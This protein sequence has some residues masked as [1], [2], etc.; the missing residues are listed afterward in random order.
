MANHSDPSEEQFSHPGARP[1]S[2]L[3]EE[4]KFRLLAENVTDVFWIRSADMQEL[5]YL[6]PAFERIW[7]RKRDELLA[8]PRAWSSF[9][10]D[11][12]RAVVVRGFE[13]LLRSGNPIA[14]EYR[15]HR[16]DGT[17]RWIQTRGFLVRDE[18]GRPLATTGIVTDITERRENELA[19]LRS[20]E[21]YREVESQLRQ[22]QKIEALG[23]LAAGVA[24]EFN[25][26]LQGLMAKATILRLRTDA[27]DLQ[28]LGSEME[29]EIRRGAT[30]TR[31]MLLFAQQDVMQKSRFSLR[32]QVEQTGELLSHVLPETIAITLETGE[33]VRVE[34]DPGQI[35]Q[36][37]VNLAINARD[38]MPHGGRLILRAGVLA[39]EAFAE[40]ED[41]G[42]GIAESMRSRIFEPFFTTRG[43]GKGTGLGLS[44]AYGIVEQHGGRI[45]VTSVP[46]DGSRFR[47][48]LPAIE[49]DPTGPAEA[50]APESVASDGKAP[51]LLVEDEPAVREGLV[52]VLEMAGYPVVAFENAEEALGAEIEQP[53]SI[54]ISDLT[55]PGMNGFTLAQQMTQR[56]ES[57]QVVLMSGYMTR[58]ERPEGW[59]FLQKPFEL[60]ELLDCLATL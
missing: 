18:S 40:V 48:I 26:L 11:E 31:Q 15:I 28:K 32:E 7:G 54:L 4:E 2:A 5:Y 34:G 20:Q 46:G 59:R 41:T 50:P 21:E 58:N 33:D 24:H 16:P 37:L 52:I 14:L 49:E 8:S 43:V 44:V 36:V 6:S 39:G 30:L 23:Q 10:V 19:L 47:I 42:E 25:N 53:P 27:P 9:I 35:Q 38:A 13:E 57:L 29:A 3:T 17:I 60:D 56:Y 22:S 55:L 51:I 45:E 1:A 12:D